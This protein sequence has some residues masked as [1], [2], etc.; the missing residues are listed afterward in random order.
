MSRKKKLARDVD[1]RGRRSVGLNMR[2]VTLRYSLQ[3]WK[4]VHT[5]ALHVSVGIELGYPSYI[6]G[7]RVML[8][9]MGSVLTDR[10]APVVTRGGNTI[11]K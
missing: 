6:V 4:S 3:S 5:Q 1:A 2:E 11:Y 9:Q 10:L 8:D 7:K